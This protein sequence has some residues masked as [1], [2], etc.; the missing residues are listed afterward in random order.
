MPLIIKPYRLLWIPFLAALVPFLLTSAVTLVAFAS[1]QASADEI[2][3]PFVA[4]SLL[5]MAILLLM[6]VPILIMGLL[7][8]A[9]IK[10]LLNGEAWV[11]WAQ[12]EFAGDWRDFAEKEHQRELKANSFP[13]ASLIVLVVIFAGVAGFTFYLLN[14]EG[15]A[16]DLPL[17]AVPL[18]LFFALI[19][20]LVLGGSLAGR[21]RS[22]A[23]YRRRLRASIP[24]VYIGKSGLYDEDSGY[25]TFRSWNERLINVYAKDGTLN[26]EIR[27]RRRYGSGT[28]SYGYYTRTVSVKVPREEEANTETLAH[29][30]FDEG[31]LKR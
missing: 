7:E 28:W 14:S 12:Y 29:R 5:S 24:H 8:R 4:M 18:A 22:H 10:R 6:G 15:Q 11:S 27:Y 20:M 13:W 19:L 23:L 26:F 25:Q 2:A 31:V 21:R 17:V 1:G 9:A 30:F 3:L 16:Q